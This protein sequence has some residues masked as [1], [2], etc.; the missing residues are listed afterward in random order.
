MKSTAALLAMMFAGGGGA[1]FSDEGSWTIAD[2]EREYNLI[3]QKK[4]ELSRAERDGIIRTVERLC[5]KGVLLK[6]DDG[7]VCRV[8][9]PHKR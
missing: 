8:I 7:F 1:A 6:G 3:M 4:S 2:T 5:A 9:K